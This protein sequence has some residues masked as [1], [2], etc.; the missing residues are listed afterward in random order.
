MSRSWAAL[1]FERAVIALARMDAQDKHSQKPYTLPATRK[2][3]TNAESTTAAPSAE[4]YA[5]L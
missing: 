1:E 3:S 2:H 4:L 5:V